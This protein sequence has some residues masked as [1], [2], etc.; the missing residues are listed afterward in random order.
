MPLGQ[1]KRGEAQPV[2]LQ[3][4]RRRK[5]N[6]EPA[7]RL[8]STESLEKGGKGRRRRGGGRNQEVLV[9]SRDCARHLLLTYARPIARRGPPG[10][11]LHACR[12][13]GIS[14]APSPWATA[15]QRPRPLLSPAKS[16]QMPSFPLHEMRSGCSSARP[17]SWP[18]YILF[19]VADPCIA[20]HR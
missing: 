9:P 3:R 4:S 8:R 16:T 1:R 7:R 10:A 12:Q 11:C 14:N 19:V 2:Q 20:R 17:H 13:S 15:R 18:K 5:A 6:D